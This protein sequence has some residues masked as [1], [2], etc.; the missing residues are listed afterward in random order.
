MRFFSSKL[1][2]RQR[3]IYGG[4]AAFFILAFFAMLWPIYPSFSRIEPRLLGMPFSLVYLV[5][6]LLACFFL[7]LAI[8]L[9]ESR[10]GEFDDE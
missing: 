8:Y 2:P 1:P 4:A 5:G 10:R 3:L 7:I 9:W 6:W